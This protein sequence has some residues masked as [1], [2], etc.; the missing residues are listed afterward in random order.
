LCDD[1]K[2]E[3]YYRL[4]ADHNTR[5]AN[6]TTGTYPEA[7]NNIGIILYSREQDLDSI[8]YYDAALEAK[9]DYHGARWHR[10]LSILRQAVSGSNKVCAELGFSDY[11]FRFYLQNS[12]TGVDMSLPLWDGVSEGNSIVVLAEQGIGDTFQ[13]MRY[14][15]RLKDYFKTVWVQMPTA[16]HELHKD[17]RV[18]TSVLETDADVS[19]P[20][21]SLSR[22]FG[23][24]SNNYNYLSRPV[25]YDFNTSK[26]KVGVVGSGNTTHNNNT[27]RSCGIHHFLKLV[28]PGI[29]LYNLQPGSKDLQGIKALN[30]STWKE[31]CSYISGLDLV[32]SVDTSVVH[33]A[34]V[35]GVPCW[36][37]MPTMDTDWRWG[38]STCSTN[39]IWY[40]TVTVF[41]NPNN[42][43]TVF[44]VVKECLRDF[45]SKP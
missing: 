6:G 20:I 16:L 1:V 29:E 13:W 23:L 24:T 11:D 3:H 18:V 40:P 31:T 2:A 45:S 10:A 36:V 38:D 5:F 7:L 17:Y 32:I 19:I 9:P 37:L 25:G 4:A 39:N 12:A 44:K 35:L 34:G 8:H 33:L 30:P 43:D 41:R 14:V 26:L 42:W 15:N 27:R 22:Y 28:M 21:C